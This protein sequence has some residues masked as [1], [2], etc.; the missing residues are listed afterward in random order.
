[1]FGLEEELLDKLAAKAKE[2]EALKA[3]IKQLK[4]DIKQIHKE[5]G[6]EI[7]DPN[8][9]IWEYAKHLEEELESIKKP[10]E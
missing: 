9:T 3:E 4:A 1:M 5:Y 6:C 8:G 2:I 7:R 10:L